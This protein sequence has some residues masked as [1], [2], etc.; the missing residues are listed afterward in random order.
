MEREEECL[1]C[2]AVG[3]RIRL[4]PAERILETDFWDVEHAYPTSIRGWLVIVLRRHAHAIHEL[5]EEELAELSHLVGVLSDLLHSTLNC[6]KE[7]LV[8]F[9]E[10][11]RF[12][13]VHF[14]L[15]PRAAGLDPNLRATNIFQALGE[16]VETPVPVEEVVA[17]SARFQALLSTDG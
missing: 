11:E 7:Y 15:I 13:H 8:Q 17:L 4:T 1:S 10:K 9:A 5:L 16:G 3:G 14:H 6:E 12:Q 2:A